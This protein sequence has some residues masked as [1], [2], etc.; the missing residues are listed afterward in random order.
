[1][2]YTSKISFVLQLSFI[3]EQFNQSKVSGKIDYTKLILWHPGKY[4]YVY[5]WSILTH[6]AKAVGEEICW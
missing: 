6:K 4:F 3:I 5:D 2:H 1:M